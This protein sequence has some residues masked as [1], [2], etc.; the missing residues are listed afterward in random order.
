MLFSR[1]FSHKFCVCGFQFSPIL[2]TLT[3]ANLFIPGGFEATFGA[4]AAEPLIH[5]F[6]HESAAGVVLDEC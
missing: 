5:E 3:E 2:E 4:G 1:L 6:L